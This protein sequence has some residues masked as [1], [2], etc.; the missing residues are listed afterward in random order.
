MREGLPL[1]DR[2]QN[3][4]E[5]QFGLMLYWIAFWELCSCRPSAFDIGEIP[6]TAV[7]H[8]ADDLELDEE[9]TEDLHYHVQAMDRVYIRHMRSKSK[10]GGK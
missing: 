10:T 9:Q 5:L 6:W 8:Y 2:I 4:P 7:Q 3:A 1:P